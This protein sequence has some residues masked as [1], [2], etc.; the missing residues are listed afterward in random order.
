MVKNNVMQTQKKSSFHLFCN[1]KDFTITA[2]TIPS[3]SY[4]SMSWFGH[5]V[6]PIENLKIFTQHGHAPQRQPGNT[7]PDK[8]KGHR[9]P[10][11]QSR[12]SRG[13]GSGLGWM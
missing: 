11:G 4:L 12:V 9:S 7:R 2:L 8:V 5:M 13:A 6:H 1:I 10:R 3:L